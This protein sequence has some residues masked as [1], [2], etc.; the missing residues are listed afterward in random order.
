M[1]LLIITG[2]SGAGKSKAIACLEDLGYYCVDN[3]PPAMITE[4][5]G[6]LEKDE[7]IEKIAVVADV[8]GRRFFA[9]LGSALKDLSA[10]GYKYKIMFLDASEK[11]LL[12]RYQE[13]RRTHPLDTAGNP[14][15]AIRDE[16]FLLEEIKGISD[17]VIDTTGLK[18]SDLNSEIIRVLGGDKDAE[19]RVSVCSFGFKYGLP[20]DADWMLDVRF[21]PNPFYVESLKNLTGK[22][23][24]VKDFVLGFPETK[25]FIARETGLIM[26]LIP[27]YKREGKYHLNIAVGCTGG[28]HRSVVVAEEIAAHLKECG[29]MVDLSAREL[30]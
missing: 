19:F 10:K 3:L 8:R 28:K 14:E 1:E 6:Y 12:M 15:K 26:D 5:L 13:T 2:K 7:S 22:N 30:K 24:K 21:I 23:K 25:S 11:T 29:V 17:Y 9:D 27:K 18:T 20:A 4:L 16:S